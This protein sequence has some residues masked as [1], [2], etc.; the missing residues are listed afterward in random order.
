[1][2]RRT[3]LLFCL[4]VVTAWFYSS[5]AHESAEVVS[6]THEKQAQ[7]LRDAER[8]LSNKVETPSERDQG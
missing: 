2:Q 4:F 1:M 6:K 5:L 8:S 7:A 3:L